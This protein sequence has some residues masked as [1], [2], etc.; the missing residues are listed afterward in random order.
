MLGAEPA[1]DV[2]LEAAADADA[3]P[4]SASAYR[5]DAHKKAKKALAFHGDPTAL[6]TIGLALI[7]TQPLDKLSAR[8]Q[9]L[10][11]NSESLRELVAVKGPLV[12]CQHYLW[13]VLGTGAGPAAKVEVLMRHGCGVILR[14]PTPVGFRLAFVFQIRLA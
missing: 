11:A 12:D 4:N 5:I 7:T 9:H 6:Q 8:L 14:H 3:D 13:D 10:D 2:R 1:G